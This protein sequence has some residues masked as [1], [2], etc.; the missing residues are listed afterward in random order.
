MRKRLFSAPFL[1]DSVVAEDRLSA[2][3]FLGDNALCASMSSLLSL[4]W[5]GF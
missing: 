2:T 3:E 1:L 4:I 5:N